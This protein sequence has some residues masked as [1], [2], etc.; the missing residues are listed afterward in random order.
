MSYQVEFSQGASKQL[1]KLP[2][3][4]QERIEATIDDLATEPRPDGVKKLKNRDNGY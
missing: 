2:Q 3:K 4:L 1:K